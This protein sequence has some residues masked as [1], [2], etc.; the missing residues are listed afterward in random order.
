MGSP[1]LWGEAFSWSPYGSVVPVGSLCPG[2]RV[3]IKGDKLGSEGSHGLGEERAVGSSWSQLRASAEIVATG[4][5]EDRLGHQR[6]EVPALN[7]HFP[8]T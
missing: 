8:V 5:E 2:C 3:R 4:E 7:L 1:S 6:A